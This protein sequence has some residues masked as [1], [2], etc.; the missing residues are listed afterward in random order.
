MIGV[1]LLKG[2]LFDGIV[3][4]LGFEV[5]A[6]IILGDAVRPYFGF[7]IIRTSGKTVLYFVA[8]YYTL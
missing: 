3:D 5:Y 4:I 7:N 8:M 2:V 1:I 6:K